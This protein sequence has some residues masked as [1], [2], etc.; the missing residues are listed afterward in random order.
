MHMD[1]EHDLKPISIDPI[2]ID[3]NINVDWDKATDSITTI[4]WTA[5]AAVVVGSWFLRH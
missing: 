1:H 3:I 4:I 5:A 2:K